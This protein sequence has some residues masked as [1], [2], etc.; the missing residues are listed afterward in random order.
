MGEWGYV[1]KDGI[2]GLGGSL[3][4]LTLMIKTNL[5]LHAIYKAIKETCFELPFPKN[6]NLSYRWP[7]SLVRCGPQQ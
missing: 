5:S 7:Y 4:S 6:S 1:G 2:S 3:F